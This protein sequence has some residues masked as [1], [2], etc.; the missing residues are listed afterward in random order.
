[1]TDLA[2]ALGR[3]HAEHAA[4]L[5]RGT[6]G[7][8]VDEPDDVL[9]ADSG[10]TD[11]TFNMV[12]NARFAE[13]A[14]DQRIAEVVASLPQGRPFTWWVGPNSLPADLSDH[15]A[16]AGFPPIPEVE[17]AMWFPLSDVAETRR[18]DLE[19]VKVSTERQLADFAAAL[20]PL[21]TPPSPT[22]PEFYAMVADKALRP[23][24]PARFFV[25]YRDGE[26]VATAEV[27]LSAG[28]AGIYNIATAVEH[29]RRGYAVAL[30]SAALAEAARAGYEAAVLQASEAGEL[31]YRKLG[32]RE[33]GAVREH[34]LA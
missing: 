4:H 32:F 24:C 29:R 19:I 33:M 10:L 9:V 26:P 7:A 11:D 16:K 8:R 13:S 30:T 2:D 31:V 22:V 28:V 14:V 12:I 27:F 15:L 23:D 34:A 17:T 20:A 5:L 3:N 25:G 18:T 6:P 1:M 21:W